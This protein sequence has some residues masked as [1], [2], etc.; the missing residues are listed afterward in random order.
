M[1]NG[2]QCVGCGA[3][4]Q[5]VHAAVAPAGRWPLGECGVAGRGDTSTEN[6]VLLCNQS[7]GGGVGFD[8]YTK[9]LSDVLGGGGFSGSSKELSLS[10]GPAFIPSSFAFSSNERLQIYRAVSSCFSI[11]ELK[12]YKKNICS[13]F[14]RLPRPFLR[15]FQNRELVLLFKKT[16]VVGL[17]LKKGLLLIV[18]NKKSSF[19]K[20]S[21]EVS[22]GVF[23]IEKKLSPSFINSQD[24]L[25]I[26][27]K[28]TSKDVYILMKLFAEVLVVK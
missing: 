26:Q 15:L 4:L 24:Q 28:K 11:K 3:R 17:S 8:F 25:K 16:C 18:L 9:L 13:V 2:H 23:F 20:K 27:L 19:Y 14:G 1:G 21:L 10:L 5:G 7:G 12:S 6:G 22:C